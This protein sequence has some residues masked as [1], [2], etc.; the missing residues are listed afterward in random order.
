MIDAFVDQSTL[1]LHAGADWDSITDIHGRF[2][3]GN[4]ELKDAWLA[5]AFLTWL[6]RGEPSA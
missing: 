1:A 2:F 5:A 4:V 6:H 3:D